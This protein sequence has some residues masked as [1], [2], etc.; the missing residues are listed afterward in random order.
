M[1]LLDNKTLQLVSVGGQ[2]APKYALLSHR[3]TE[4]ETSFQELRRRQNLEK[5]GWNKVRNF[6]DLARGLRYQYV[7]IDTCCIDKSSSAELQEAINSMFQWYK[8]SDV[9]FIYLN[10]VS[11]SRKNSWGQSVDEAQFRSSK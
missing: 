2:Q 11:I 7:W 4:G 6:Y 9:C 8:N 3:W 1:Y 10:D 5:K